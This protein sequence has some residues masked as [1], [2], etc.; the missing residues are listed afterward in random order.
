M[1]KLFL[2]L[3][4]LFAFASNS[5]ATHVMG[6]DITYTW[7]SGNDY[8][9]T[10]T[11]YR[12]CSGSTISETSQDIDLASSCGNFSA[13]L[14]WV[15]TTNVSQVCAT[16]TTTCNGGTLPGTEQYIFTGIV[17]LPPCNN[18]VMSWSLCCRN[19]GITN[20]T[21]PGSEDL[22]IQTT[23]NNV[24]APGNN[25]PQFLALPTPYLCTNQLS[26]YNHGAADI[27]GDSLYYQFTTPLGGPAAPIAFNAGY[28]TNNPMITASGMN[29]NPQTGEMCLTPTVAQICV[30]SVIV[31]EYR[32]NVLIGTYIREMQVVVSNTCSNT[33]PYAGSSPNCGNVG[34]ITNLVAGPTVIQNDSNSFSMCPNDN[35]CFS[36]N[37]SDPDGNN[38][39][40][41]SNAATA[42]PGA[43]LTITGNGT[44]NPVLNFC[45]TPTSLDSGIN[46]LTINLRDDACPISASQYYTYDITVF[47]Q[48]YA[49][50]DQVICGPQWAQLNALGGAGYSWSVISGDPLVPGVNITCNPC[51]SPQV[52]PAITTTYLLTSS[53]SAACINTDTVT[54]TVVPDYFV[55]PFGD[56]TLCD[57]LATP[58]GVNL[59][60]AT[61]TY[62]VSWDNTS[63]LSN[64]NIATPTAFPN[65]T[66][67]YVAT[68]IS[69]FGCIK[70]DS[71]TVNVNPPP[72][73]TITPGDT[74]ICQGSSLNFD[75][76]STCTYTLNMFDTFGDGWNGQS[77]SVYDNGNLVGTYTLSTGSTGSATFPITSGN[78]ITLVYGTGSFQSES[79][80]NLVNG[81]GNNQFSVAAGG[82]SGWVNGNTYYTGIGNCGPTLSNYT[83]NWSPATGLSATNIQNPIATPSTT[84]TYTVT[85][86]DAG[87]CSVNRSQTVTV[88]PNYTVAT[89]QSDTAVCLGETVN[90]TATTNPTGSF[91]YS[92]SPA[93]IM[94]NATSA[95][96]TATFT[97]P[98]INTIVVTV[99]NGGGCVKTDTMRVN[100]APTYAPNINIV[101]NDTTI[102]C[103]DSVIVNLD[104]GGGIPASCGPS[105]SVA[106]SGPTTPRTVGTSSGANTSTSYPAPY[107]NYYRNA[108]HQFLYTAAELNA[109]GFTGGKI[110]QIGWEITAINGTTT[111]NSYTIKMKCTNITS[112][113]TWQTGL[114]Q[115][116]NP[117]T[118]NIT[119]GWNMHTFDTAYEWDG[120]SNIVVEICF[121][122]LS[123]TYTN[124]S[125]T[126]WGATA[127]T[128]AIRYT[129]D[130][131]PACP[132][133]NTPT[134]GTNRPITRFTTCPTTPNPSAFNYS[135]TPTAGVSN[136]NIQ[137][138][139]LKPGATTTYF[140][141]VTD[142]I[143]GCFDT[144][145]INVTVTSQLSATIQTIPA[146]CNGSNDGQIIASGIGLNSPFTFEFFDSTGTVLL[147]S[148]VRPTSDTLFNI[149]SGTY[150]VTITDVLGCGFDTLVTLSPTTQIYLTNVSNDSLICING[151]AQIS[152]SG[153]GGTGTI[154]IIWDNGLV[155]NGPHTVSPLSNTVYH[156]YAQDAMGCTS[157]IDSVVITLRD[158]IQLSNITFGRDTICPEDTTILTIPNAVGG[159]GAGYTY[160]WFD[161]NNNPLG[162]GTSVVV[163][164]LTSPATYTVVVGDNCT[165]PTSSRSVTIYWSPLPK[166]SFTFVNN[167]GC[168]PI[169][170]SFVN[171]TP[172]ATNI[173]SVTWNFG[174]GSTSNTILNVDHLY[175]SAG[176]Y[177]VSLTVTSTKGCVRDTTLIDAVCAYGYPTA[178]FSMNPQPTDLTNP[179]IQFTNESYGNL[180]NYWTIT[181][182][183][184]SQST[185]IN[186]ISE[187]P[188]DSAGEYIV[189]LT[190]ENSYGC[191]DSTFR[192]VKIDGLYL[193]YMP[194]GFTPNGDNLND[195]FKP[196]GEGIDS[197]NYLFMIFNRWGEKLF[198]TDDLNEGWDGTYNGT[199]VQT[200]TYI[201]R[202]KAK[203]LYRNVNTE[204]TGFINLTR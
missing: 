26:I 150:L 42:I 187:F 96:P 151:S 28:S 129:S 62:T 181:G 111:Y 23:L 143:G 36:I 194:N 20:L 63:T 192:V 67:T 158:T 77:I 105:A 156:V 34:G 197:K 109:L 173:N 202:I 108:K 116:F 176:C 117:K 14:D 47:D 110:T 24:L 82:M 65:N 149:S 195:T 141:T 22:Y 4:V 198:E 113:T 87:G 144:D 179:F 132:A 191:L 196:V 53:L 99:D 115:V 163:T 3:I 94:N 9:V 52:K 177:D 130:S 11:L 154:S 134:T 139:V 76:Q 89:T 50:P 148:N 169:T 106:C 120:I 30:V 97:T 107:G 200:D 80:F 48:P 66:T 127:F 84:T 193:F 85:L 178:D 32:N 31:T 57:Y 81:L 204:H 165:T 160:N 91:N 88:V 161:S 43:I 182:G 153:A 69:P 95:N 33:A 92:W 55:I 119:T 93:S 86:T 74:T 145:S 162:T 172:N 104:L 10:L 35:I 147:Q 83:F 49:G 73:L 29:L 137:N 152:A 114:T 61:G 60:P 155:G 79:S 124:N 136:P 19:D 126:P 170:T 13:T 183:S 184:P 203:E 27:D 70:K 128:S 102:G 138:P 186:P 25:S 1:R 164:P 54:V 41:S 167:T 122:N 171:T 201:W 45:W 125:V 75:L 90:F 44:Q 56:T 190:V 159:S 180:N 98:G 118:V 18:W 103:S 185:E 16:A 121:D 17:T 133:T 168:Y 112:L 37:V 101:N 72:A 78:T 142:P 100:V 38:I 6:A 188:S 174:D 175:S 51:T 2:S 140:V 157:S 8:Q 131:N 7:V 15:S 146:I 123:V 46:V 64:S 39:T 68:V 135:W 12:D 40:I 5:Y 199:P 59:V 58:I 71:V 189:W 21:S 166:P